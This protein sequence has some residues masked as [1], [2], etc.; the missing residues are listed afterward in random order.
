MSVQDYLPR[1]PASIDGLTSRIFKVV[2]LLV[3]VFQSTLLHDQIFL[4]HALKLQGRSICFAS[5]DSIDVLSLCILKAFR[6]DV[7]LAFAPKPLVLTRCK[8]TTM[9]GSEASGPETQAPSSQLGAPPA[10]RAPG[11]RG[12]PHRPARKRRDAGETGLGKQ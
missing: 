5:C 3:I 2:N 4:T 8:P 12:G 1:Q 7:Q 6:D 11:R 10:W 9:Q